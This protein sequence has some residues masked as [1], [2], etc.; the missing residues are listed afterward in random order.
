MGSNV[1]GVYQL[2][3]GIERYLQAFP[4]GGFWRGKNFV[5]DKREAISAGNI[6]GDGG[7]IRK[8]GAKRNPTDAS[9][10]VDNTNLLSWGTEC[11]KCTRPW[12]RYV[13][14]RKCYTCGVPILV[15]D[16][17]MSHSCM[18]KKNKK[19]KTNHRNGENKDTKQAD[20]ETANDDY[21]RCPLCIEEGV[22]VPAEQ[23]EYT[24]NGVRSKQR[25]NSFSEGGEVSTTS[26][27]LQAADRPEHEVWDKT[28]GNCCAAREASD[29]KAAKSVLKW[30]GGH[31]AMKKQ[32][33]RF[34]RK[35]CQFG[36]DC[37]RKDCFFYHPEKSGNWK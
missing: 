36:V 13:G 7:V 31:A 17:C 29:K 27:M 22:T 21:V 20:I 4:D 34:S 12:D 35:L 19:R 28:N 10:S 25:S 16:E 23:V 26:F 5:F 3:G 30:G 14:K 15:C 6:N 37:V 33:R 8:E 32:K 1:N 24:D 9:S 2:R 11:A 18:H